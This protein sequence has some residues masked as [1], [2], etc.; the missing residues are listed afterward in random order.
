MRHIET[1]FL[2]TVVAICVLGLAC[3]IFA[4]ITDSQASRKVGIVLGTV[5]I[6]IAFIPLLIGV[7][8]TCIQKIRHILK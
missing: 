7:I 5:G 2:I 3:Q 1:K 6:L 8:D 4:Y